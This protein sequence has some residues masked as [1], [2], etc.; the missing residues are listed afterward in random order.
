MCSAQ[1][2][3]LTAPVSLHKEI[4]ISRSKAPFSDAAAFIQ[5]FFSL[6]DSLANFIY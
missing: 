1:S 5:L 4:N 2:F 6:P 3:M